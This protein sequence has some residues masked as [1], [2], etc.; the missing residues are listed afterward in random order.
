METNR[1]P[2]RLA[3][4][5]VLARVRLVTCVFGV[6]DVLPS[7][8]SL[9]HGRPASRVL[10]A[11]LALLAIT[12]MIVSTLPRRRAA[13]ADPLLLAPLAVL[14][15]STLVD[16]RPTTGLCI[17]ICTA[18]SLYG[19]TRSAVLRAAM[20]L[21]VVPLAA[22]LNPHSPVAW[23]DPSVL[24][25]VPLTALFTGLMRALK[26][27][28]EAQ[29][30]NGAR[31]ALLASTG[32]RLL[33]CTD[34]AEV[35]AIMKDAAGSLCELTPGLVV[36][37]V[38]R[39]GSDWRVLRAY[40]T[41]AYGVGSGVG[42]GLVGAAVP[43]GDARATDALRDL[44]PGTSSWL[45]TA[46]HVTTAGAEEARALIGLHKPIPQAV[47]D[48]VISFG[49]QLE[50]AEKTCRAHAEM[51]HRAHHDELTAMPNRAVFLA[52]LTQAVQTSHAGGGC[53]VM[54]IDL[55]DFKLVNDTLGHGAG[56]SLLVEIARRMAE[57]VSEHGIAARFGGDEFAVLLP[58]PTSPDL[59]LDLAH[60]LRARLL[61]PVELPE[62]TVSVGC[63]IGLAHSRP[64][65]TP[66]DLTR[67]ADIA[68]YAAKAGGK[69][70][71]EDFSE[72]RH[73]GIAKDRRSQERGRGLVGQQV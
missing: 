48:S 61:E 15:G 25:L 64:G 47:Y 66:E 54:V 1:W 21:P 57:V 60:Q 73:G 2:S 20:F 42:D 63:S 55:D 43:E 52:R 6:L 13:L 17:G 37:S 39:H 46:H 71:V 19:S 32:R 56:D 34:V 23:Y 68:M 65:S 58:E 26:S 27:S 9:D 14:A 53:A 7:L 31:E 11:A 22:L 41:E 70:R 24:S 62:G 4:T 33:G 29:Q 10:A 28:L 5:S 12:G 30:E 36:L 35:R 45:S 40:G 16:P 69:N 18:Q 51:T 59:A 50:M 38:E 8:G 44:V 49:A 72:D 3:G 67:N